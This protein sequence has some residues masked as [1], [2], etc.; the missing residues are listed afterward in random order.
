MFLAQISIVMRDNTIVTSDTGKWE[1]LDS[2]GEADIY[3]ARIGEESYIVKVFSEEYTRL[4]KPLERVSEI[5]RRLIRVRHRCK[6]PLSLFARGLPV[7]FASHGGRAVL[8]FND[9]EGF[10]TIAEILSSIE[11]VVDYLTSIMPSDRRR[12]AIDVAQGI[13]CLEF[14]DVLHADLTTMN[15]AYGL[16]K[17]VKGV[18]LFDI[19]AAAIVAHPDYP[20][21]VL[22]ARDTN[23]MPIEVLPELGIPANPPP[24]DDLPIVL[25]PATLDSNTL[26]WISWVMTWYGLQLV[27]Y[28]YAGMS[29]FQ[30]LKRLDAGEWREIVEAE[31]EY[32]YPG[33]WPPR[34]MLDLGLLDADE[35]KALRSTWGE[36][37]EEFVALT[38]QFFV[39]DIAEKKRV[40][41]ATMSALL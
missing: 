40:P 41:T 11:S 3:R 39:V 25:D 36:L 30:G 29:L 31:K 17:D 14:V 16:Y 32:G 15:A 34:S 28:V 37:G 5:M 19:E 9:I 23:Y 24:L 8:V 38:Y 20:L 13:A 7:G 21:V 4:A 35:Y 12:F 33:G 27:G 6:S 1:L 22:P 10:K 26:S 2:G 18:Y